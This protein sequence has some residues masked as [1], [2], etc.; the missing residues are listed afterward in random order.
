MSQ[1]DVAAEVLVERRSGELKNGFGNIVSG[2]L[3]G[4]VIVLLEVDTSLLLRRVI[5]DSEKFALNARVG[6]TGNVLAVLPL[7]VTRATSSVG[8]AATAVTAFLSA[9][10]TATT[11]AT[12]AA[13]AS[14]VGR[15]TWGSVTRE[16][17]LG[18]AVPVVL[19]GT[20]V[21]ANIGQY[22]SSYVARLRNILCP[23]ALLDT[24]HGRAGRGAAVHGRRGTVR[25]RS[26][27]RGR[28]TASAH[29]RRDVRAATGLLRTALLAIGSEVE[30]SHVELISHIDSR[31]LLNW[32]SGGI[33]VV[34]S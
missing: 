2:S 13:A 19:A 26:R 8:T 32:Y 24:V 21:L 18:T 31:R 4:D 5:D 29:V 3:D 1:L 25:D 33:E 34:K 23:G 30:T 15:S 14:S 28:A 27:A 11:A 22:N 7:A 17:G 10:A 20:V 16:A 9:I 12:P 6:G